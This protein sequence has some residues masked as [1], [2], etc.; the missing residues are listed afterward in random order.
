MVFK[1]ITFSVPIF[2]SL[3]YVAPG[4]YIFVC[5]PVAAA[6]SEKKKI[7]HERDHMGKLLD[8]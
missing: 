7:L 1:S 2:D 4:R 3:R 5:S 8:P 6:D